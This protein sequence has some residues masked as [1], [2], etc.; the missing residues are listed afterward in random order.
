MKRYAIVS[1][2][3]IY[4]ENDECAKNKAEQWSSEQDA[5]F[6]NKMKIT[7]IVHTPKGSMEQRLVYGSNDIKFK[8]N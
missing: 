5:T 4:A 6:D 7:E 2:H 3:Y 1:Q 8:T